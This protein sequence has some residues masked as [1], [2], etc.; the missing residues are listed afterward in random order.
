MTVDESPTGDMEQSRLTPAAHRD[1]LLTISREE[2]VLREMEAKGVKAS[3]LRGSIERDVERL[4]ST[5]HVRSA[6]PVGPETTNVMAYYTRWEHDAHE[7]V[8]VDLC[9]IGTSIICAACTIWMW[10]GL[11]TLE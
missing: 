11:R 2:R 7:A 5:K 3:S 1:S 4:L 6:P 10:F 8:T 9:I